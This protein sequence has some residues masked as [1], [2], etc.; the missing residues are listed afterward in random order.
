VAEC[1][2]S[3]QADMEQLNDRIREI[4]ALTHLLLEE[5]VGDGRG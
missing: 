1:G 4:E 3:E 5:K 2:E